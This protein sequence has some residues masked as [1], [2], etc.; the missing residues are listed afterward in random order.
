[1]ARSEGERWSSV[2]TLLVSSLVTFVFTTPARADQEITNHAYVRQDGGTDPVIARCSTDKRQQNEP[3]IAISPTNPDLMTAGAN[4]YCP[5]PTA[6]DAWAGFYY[7]SDRGVTW[8]NSL[9]PGYAG[10]TSLQGQ[11]SPLRQ[12][13]GSAGDPV[14]E[15]DNLGHLYYAGIAFNRAQPQNGDLWVARYSWTSGP[16]PQYEL[17]TLVRQ[18]TPALAGMFNDKIQ[19][20]VDRGA[21]GLNQNIYAF[22]SP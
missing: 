14:Q 15:W 19:L 7:S 6:G 17:T 13:V 3:A 4:D 1:M 12:R 9:L 21:G 8:T 16:K 20:Q 18:G 10:D 11:A 5:V 22:V 2:F